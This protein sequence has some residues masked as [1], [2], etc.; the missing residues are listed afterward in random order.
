VRDPLAVDR[1]RNAVDDDWFTEQVAAGLKYRPAP[2]SDRQRS[3]GIGDLSHSVR[4]VP[5]DPSGRIVATA[6]ARP[7]RRILDAWC[8][9]GLD[10]PA[11]HT[12]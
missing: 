10:G 4:R 5:I 9:I 1:S 11:G 6:G 2:G 3:T 7:Y 8:A 12:M